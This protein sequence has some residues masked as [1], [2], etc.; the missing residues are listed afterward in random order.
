[1]KSSKTKAYCRPISVQAIERTHQPT[2]TTT[3]RK[4]GKRGGATGG[5][6]ATKRGRKPAASVA[7]AAEAE[8]REAEAAAGPDHMV[9]TGVCPFE[10][11][12]DDMLDKMLS[13]HCTPYALLDHAIPEGSRV[14]WAK[15]LLKFF[16]PMAGIEYM[17][18]WTF[19]KKTVMLWM[20]CH[21]PMASTSGHLVNEQFKAL[22]KVILY[23]GFESDPDTHLGIEMPTVEMPSL[24]IMPNSHHPEP[25]DGFQIGVFGLSH[26]KSWRRFMAAQV[27][28]VCLTQMG[29]LEDYIKFLGPEKAKSF[30]NIKV[31]VLT[32]SLTANMDK[33]RG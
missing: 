32:G 3:H 20:G 30:S 16:P 17:K 13:E 27:L 33:A 31:M 12:L 22:V 15:H 23:A 14:D 29:K 11:E 1:M 5:A 28:M 21:H 8:L 9:L 26:I 24:D 7:A 2:H 4:M 19:G 18:E 10:S 25:I 6:V